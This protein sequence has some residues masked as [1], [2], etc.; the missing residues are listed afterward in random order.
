MLRIRRWLLEYDS[1]TFAS[2]INTLQRQHF[3]AQKLPTGAARHVHDWFNAKA[4]ALL[5]EASQLRVSRKS[6]TMDNTP[7]PESSHANGAETA[8]GGVYI[9][10]NEFEDDE[11]A[12]QSTE[13]GLNGSYTGEDQSD[14]NDI[15]VMETFA[16]QTQ[17]IRQPQ[18]GSA[19]DDDD[20]DD[21][22]AV[23]EGEEPLQ[24]ASVDVPPVF[25][26]LDFGETDNLA[27]IVKKRLRKGHEQV[28]EEQPKWCLLAKV[29]KEIED[30]IARV[31]ESHAGRF[32]VSIR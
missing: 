12:L 10:S 14:M 6:L 31:T 16:T 21:L 3:N 4:A 32:T 17:T 15:D 13:N 28:L 30:T 9:P 19:A 27:A 8:N 2:Y 24:A 22:V 5:V 23:A 29:L 25:R 18:N 11:A 7:E 20:D 1:A 26:P